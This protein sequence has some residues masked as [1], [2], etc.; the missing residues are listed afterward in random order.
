VSKVYQVTYEFKGV[1]V[2]NVFLD[3]SVQVPEDFQSWRLSAQDEW[4]WENQTNAKK[5][6]TDTSWGNAVNILPT[7]QLRLV[8]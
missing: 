3:D 4:L 2:V 1:E 5:I 8:E 7:S 6:Y